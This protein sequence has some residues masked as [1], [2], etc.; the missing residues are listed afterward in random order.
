MA[1]FAP[2]IPLPSLPTE[3]CPP[4]RQPFWRTT[5][6]M[7]NAAEL[8]CPC[9]F[10]RNLPAILPLILRVFSFVDNYNSHEALKHSILHAGYGAKEG[11]LRDDN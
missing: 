8:L 10:L 5:P 9:S 3:Q 4:P 1:G 7:H 11:G 2:T 6:A